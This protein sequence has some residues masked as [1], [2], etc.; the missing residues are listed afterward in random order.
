MNTNT[1]N[2]LYTLS[3]ACKLLSISTATGRNWI[4]SGRLVSVT[5]PGQKPAFEEAFLLNLKEALANGTVSGLKSRRNKAFIN[6]KSACYSYIPKDSANHA[7]LKQLTTVLQQNNIILDDTLLLS[8]LRHCALQLITSVFPAI[9]LYEELLDNLI[10]SKKVTS[11]ARKYPFLF[12]IPFTYI[13]SEDT[14]GFLYLSLQALKDRKASG[15]Y[16]TPAHLAKQL[17]TK[18]LPMLDVSKTVLDPSCGTGVFLLQLPEYLPLQNIYGTDIN[19]VS[20][21]LTRINLALK[22]RISTSDELEIL[23]KNITATD[24]LEAGTISTYDIILGNPPWGARLSEDIKE[25]YRSHFICA[26]GTSVEIFDLFIEQALQKLTPVTGIVSFILPQALLT[27]KSHTKIRE[28]LLKYTSVLSVEYL[29]EAFE[30]VHC[31]S[32]ILTFCKNSR[33]PF[34]KNVSVTLA[35]G[36]NFSTAV[37]RT[38][39]ATSFSFSLTDEAYL[40][41]QKI[42]SCPNCTTLVDK[43]VFALGIVTGNNASLLQTTPSAGLEPV[44]RG[45]DIS[46]FHINSVSGYLSFHPDQ[47]QQTAPEQIYR[48]PEKLFYRFINRRLIFAYDTTGLLSLNSCNILIPK[49]PGLSVKYVLAILNSNMAQFV[50]EQKYHSVKI[51]RSHLEQIPIPLA[52]EPTQKE[53]VTLVDMLMEQAPAS[54]AYKETYARLDR[55][56][57]ALYHLTPEEY[58][59]ICCS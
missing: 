33:L 26:T 11:Q 29:G 2:K 57:A 41:L 12:E 52:D 36:T 16:Y 43:S 8:L 6:E 44:I 3:E 48:A 25:K 53:I 18:H 31:P 54:F 1:L 14:L 55:E 58:E 38:V 40:L 30:Q 32:I 37:E 9:S 50:F 56:I 27:V 51:L 23:K 7:S 42:M 35:N 49:I 59:L 10:D 45:T 24:F 4:K 47:F 19:P 13:F 46:K 17:V 39:Y 15:S 21:T 5:T 22:H 28:L 34:F 20:V